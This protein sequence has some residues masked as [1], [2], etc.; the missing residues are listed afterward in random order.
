MK[1]EPIARISD[2]AHGVM[3]SFPDVEHPSTVYG[4]TKKALLIEN[5]SRDETDSAYGVCYAGAL[6][7][8][9]GEHVFIVKAGEYFSIPFTNGLLVTNAGGTENPGSGIIAVRHKYRCLRNVGG[10]V[11]SYGRLKYI[12][13]CSD[14]MLIGPP[15][16]GDPCLNFLRFPRGIE[17]TAHTHPTIR[18]GVILSGHGVCRTAHGDEELLP[19]KTFILYPD[20]VHAFSTADSDGMS[21]S[22]FHPDTDTGPTHEDHP[23]IRRT[24]VDG[25]P[26]SDI[27]GIHTKDLES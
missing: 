12:D 4:F 8:S 23:M 10:P 5:T 13:G 24:I 19:G 20:A 17:Q 27:P 18:A 14:T 15:L 26:A 6:E 25:V 22:V 21:L 7:V 16:R 3:E 11:E 1:H 2:L 9:S